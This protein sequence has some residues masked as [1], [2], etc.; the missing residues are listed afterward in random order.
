MST[1]VYK[2]R[3]TAIVALM[4]SKQQHLVLKMKLA[5][6]HVATLGAEDEVKECDVERTLFILKF[7]LLKSFKTIL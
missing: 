6:Y 5:D 3:K 4:L 7:V 2:S 1:V